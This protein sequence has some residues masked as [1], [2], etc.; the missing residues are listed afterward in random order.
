[1]ADDSGTGAQ[2]GADDDDTQGGVSGGTGSGDS[3]GTGGAQGG[4][5]SGSDSE[6]DTGDKARQEALAELERTRERMRAADKRASAAES[7]LKEL[8]TK[9]LPE[10]E[11]IKG[12]L[13]EATADRDRLSEQLRQT[14][15]ESAFLRSNR[16]EWKNPGTAL[17]L[18]DLSGVDIDDEGRVTGLD[19]AL[20]ALAKSDPYLVKEKS[21]GDEEDKGKP[22]GSTGAPGNGGRQG[23]GQPKKGQ[24]AARFP[25]LRQRGVGS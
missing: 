5:G 8:E 7:R 23:S 12:E 13:Q 17:K 11:K 6:Q 1:M 20:E 4:S 16:I 25:A 15:L 18:A 9:D 2:S 10:I 3:G 14:R 21:E 19:K 22:S 24:L